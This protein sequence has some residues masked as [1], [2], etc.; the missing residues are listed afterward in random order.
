MGSISG[1]RYKVVKVNGV[2]LS[3][4]IAGKKEKPKR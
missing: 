4:I 2:A 3:E 1:I